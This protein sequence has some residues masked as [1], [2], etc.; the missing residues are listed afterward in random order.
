MP[1]W[2]ECS[3]T[4]SVDI[5]VFDDRYGTSIR[6]AFPIGDYY[7]ADF[8]D[9]GDYGQIKVPLSQVEAQREVW[10]RYILERREW[11]MSLP[12]Y[13]RGERHMPP[14]LE[15]LGQQAGAW[16]RVDI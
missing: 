13:D 4:N 16:C 10:D 11:L 8:G 7:I 1:E 12:K 15:A 14:E 2:V 9:Y 6:E 5:M 3:V